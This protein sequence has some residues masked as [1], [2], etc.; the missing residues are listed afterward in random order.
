[1]ETRYGTLTSNELVI[2]VPHFLIASISWLQLIF[3]LNRFTSFRS[4]TKSDIFGLF[5]YLLAGM[6]RWVGAMSIRTHTI[7]LQLVSAILATSIKTAAFF[8]VYNGAFEL[9]S[10]QQWIALALSIIITS[11]WE[12][13]HRLTYA[14]DSD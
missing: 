9:P 6:M 3:S 1:M 5:M 8:I 4:F 12:V 13:S 11:L 14:L 10:R 7:F 2:M